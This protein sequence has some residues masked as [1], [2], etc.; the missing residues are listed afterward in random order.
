[1]ATPVDTQTCR[2]VG[3]P[4]IGRDESETPPLPEGRLICATALT[5]KEAAKQTGTKEPVALDAR[6]LLPSRTLMETNHI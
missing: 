1:M 5:N 6:G 4:Y 3:I 2:N